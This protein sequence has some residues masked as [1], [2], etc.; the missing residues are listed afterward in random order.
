M[1]RY[2]HNSPTIAIVGVGAAGLMTAIHATR[3]LRAAND[4]TTRVLAIDGAKKLGAKIL[5]A[6]G[7]RCNV[8][9]HAV[10]ETAYA[11]S[12]TKAIR[13]VLR[14]FTVRDT[15]NFFSEL[16]VELKREPTGKLFPTT[17]KARTVLDALLN[18]ARNADVE[19]IYPWRVASIEHNDSHFALHEED[20]DDTITATH[21][22][23]AT[24]GK[25]LPKTGSD[26]LG[27]SFAKQLG[28]TTTARIFP[29]LVPIVLAQPS[30]WITELSGTAA[31]VTLEVRSSTGKRLASF[32]NDT[33]CTHFGISGPAAMDISRYYFDALADTAN[34]QLI[35][36][37]LPD[38][39]FES[40]D[41]ALLDLKKRTPLAF[42]REHLPERLARAICQQAS[43]EPTSPAH[44]LA[45]E[46]R[47]RL[48][49]AL[50]ATELHVSRHRGFTFA[51]TTAGGIPLDQID[52]KTMSSKHHPNLSIVGEILDVD[53]RIGGFNFQWAWATGY[54]AGTS[55]AQS[56]LNNEPRP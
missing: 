29:A 46:E 36:R 31:R 10:D 13:T 14:R 33:L 23:L 35:A 27:Y 24:G 47:R 49:H 56:I 25:A 6:G 16:G 20:S 17:D 51:E 19:L 40:I 21:L 52:L 28:H 37:W 48:A 15:T 38:H 44:Q 55:I 45:R 53:G 50:D 8:T 34:T 3:T 30:H 7:G 18:A 5:V 32:T 22:V 11:G 12:T 41:R 42:L 26:G 9:H 2:Q 39:S 1:S 54:I 4:H 43:I